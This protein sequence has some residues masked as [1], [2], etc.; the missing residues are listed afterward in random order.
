MWEYKENNKDNKSNNGIINP[1]VAREM[2]KFFCLKSACQMI[3]TKI[4]SIVVS[5]HCFRTNKFSLQLEALSDCHSI[6]V[7]IR[8]ITTL[9]LLFLLFF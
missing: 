2:T 1:T 8:C 4:L 6:K 7:T 5:V 3:L 9:L